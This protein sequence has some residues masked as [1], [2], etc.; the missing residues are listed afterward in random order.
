MGEKYTISH[1]EITLKKLAF[2]QILALVAKQKHFT[3][4]TYITHYGG[5]LF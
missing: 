5:P 4:I 2:R 1:K 3:P